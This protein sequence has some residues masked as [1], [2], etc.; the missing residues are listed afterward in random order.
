MYIPPEALEPGSWEYNIAFVANEEPLTSTSFFIV[1]NL[2]INFFCSSSET[3]GSIIIWASS[4]SAPNTGLSY[5][6]IEKKN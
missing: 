5:F 4:N 3:S 6:G 2:L 1:S